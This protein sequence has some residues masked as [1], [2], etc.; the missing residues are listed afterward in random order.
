MPNNRVCARR[1][2]LPSRR[3]TPFDAS[4][5]LFHTSS[6]HGIHPSKLSPRERHL[7]VSRRKSPHTVS[8]SP[9]AP[10]GNLMRAGTS[11]SGPCSF[12]ESLAI[13]PVISGLIAGCSLGVHS[14]RACGREPGSGFRPNSSRV[15]G[16]RKRRLRN[17][18]HR[19]SISSCLDQAESQRQAEANGPTTLVEFLRLY[20]PEHSNEANSRAMGSPL[21]A[22]RVT[23]EPTDGLCESAPLYRSCS[24]VTLG[25]EHTSAADI[26]ALPSPAYSRVL[27]P[28]PYLVTQ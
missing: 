23:A 7:A 8:R 15:L 17:L 26:A 4:L 5:V 22:S 14:S 19:V 28:R 2:W 13:K 24:A 21:A 20:T 9:R 1:V 16:G 6:A 12:R 18:H 25:A 3:F 11:V 10:E 27:C